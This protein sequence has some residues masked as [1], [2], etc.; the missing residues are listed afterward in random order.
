MK[1]FVVIVRRRVRDEI[2]RFPRIPLME[3]MV[4]VRRLE[5]AGRTSSLPGP[6][7]GSS[8]R[9]ERSFVRTLLLWAFMQASFAFGASRHGLACF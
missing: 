6:M 5:A 3:D 8:R 7:V 9:W 2:V 4:F 1:L